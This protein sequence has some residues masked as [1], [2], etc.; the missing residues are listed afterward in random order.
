MATV[1]KRGGKKAKGYWYAS[2]VDHTGKRR[3]KCTKT[4]DKATAER[5]AKKQESD[6]ALRRDGVIDPTLDAI[7]K[8]SQRTIESHLEDFRAKMVTA[9]RGRK[10]INTTID[11]VRKIATDRGYVTA[12]DIEADGC[13][14]LRTTDA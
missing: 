4:T 6:V 10:H 3:T 12:S 2:W 8:E 7:S 13:E 11:Y 9:G 5:I 1:Y 14:H